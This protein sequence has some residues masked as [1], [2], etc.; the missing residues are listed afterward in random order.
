MPTKVIMPQF[1]ESV[2]EGTIS[3]WLKAEGERVNEFDPLLEINTD[4]VDTEIPSPASGI[5]LKIIAAEGA[6]VQVGNELALIGEEDEFKGKGQ[7][8][9][10]ETLPVEA[11][12]SISQTGEKVQSTPDQHTVEVQDRD[13][14]Q[15]PS[16][17][18]RDLGFISPVVAKIASEHQVDLT[19][20]KGTGL[21]GRI[22]KK[23]VLEYLEQPQEEL[24][25]FTPLEG[26]E[27]TKEHILTTSENIPS[28]QT[29]EIIPHTPV[30]RAIADHMVLSKHTSPHVTTVM[31]ADLT[32]IISHRRANK[33]AYARQG[34]KLTFTPYFASATI[35]G[36][37]AFP[38]VNSS[39]SDEGIIVHP[40]INLGIATSLGD[41]GLIVPV[42]KNADGLS[43][44]GLARAINDLASRA[45]SR[46]LNPDEVKGGTFTIT[47]H[48]ISGSLFAS[49]IINQPQCAI[50]GVGVIQ[51]RVV[52]VEDQNRGDSIAIRPM[53]YVSLTFDH[54]MLDGAISDHFLAKLVETLEQWRLE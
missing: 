30:R 51:K 21:G 35:S 17:H 13:F 7:P 22:T 3:K 53:V 14:E 10:E 23:D 52:V 50:L 48:G 28:T 2:N 46:Q 27:E 5:L 18:K 1:G 29:G 24:A 43:L 4:K 39:W 25:E 15:V 31:E 41:Q 36:L 54:R 49:P 32:N 38:L 45:R 16:K 26:K 9:T 34:A 44:L 6:T 37:K 12:P 33:D 11:P 40:D 42:I 8:E 47:N 19:K 20:I